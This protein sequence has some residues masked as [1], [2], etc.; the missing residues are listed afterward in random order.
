MTA[1]GIIDR[2]VLGQDDAGPVGLHVPDVQLLA[3]RTRL[4]RAAG[5]RLDR[6]RSRRARNRVGRARDCSR[7]KWIPR[8]AVRYSKPDGAL[9]QDPIEYAPSR[10]QSTRCYGSVAE[11]AT[12]LTRTSS[13]YV[14]VPDTDRGARRCL[15][16]G[17]DGRRFGKPFGRACRSFLSAV[18]SPIRLT[19]RSAS[20]LRAWPSRLDAYSSWNT[21]ANTVGTALA[22]AIA[23]D[24][25]RRM[26]TYDALAHR[27]FTFTL[28]LDDYA[29]HDE[30]RPDLNATLAAQGITDHT[31]LPPASPRS[32]RSATARCSGVTPSKFS[33]SSTPAITSLPCRSSCRGAAPSKPR[34]TLG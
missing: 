17:H 2:L 28:F 34:S 11:C 25:G 12:T 10:R 30:V 32:L 22:E 15:R 24:A 16:R 19:S 3:G 5:A 29:F 31:L 33:R 8:I 9:Y 26:G 20:S 14:R 4:R 23:A 1:A 18:L 21:N 7:S 6:A 27:T 13:L